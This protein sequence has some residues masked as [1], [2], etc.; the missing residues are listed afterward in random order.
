LNEIRRKGI[1]GPPLGKNF[2]FFIDDLNMPAL[3]VYGAQPPIEL[4]RQW[5][6]FKG[7]YDRKAIGEFRN[8]VDISFC[9]AMGP[10]GGGRN[11]ISMRLTRHFNHLSFVEME[12]DVM[13]T[14]FSTISK[15]WSKNGSEQITELIPKLVSSCLTVYKTIS[16]QLLPT[17]AKSHYTFNLRDLSK[18]FQ[19]ILMVDIKSVENGEDLA[20]LWFHES[21]RVF[22]D[23]LI[24][25]EDRKWFSD[26]LKERMKADFNLN[27]DSVITKE[28]I[29]YGDFMVANTDNKPYIEINDFTQMKKTIEDYLEDYNQI[30]TPKMKLVLFLDAMRHIARIS[31]IIRQPFGNALLLG[32]GG[33]GRQS[34]TRLAAHM[35]DY[36]CFQIELSKNYGISEWKE[37]LKKVM[38]DA[39]LNNAQTVFL[40]N[41][42]QIKSES[43][44]EDLNNILNSGDVPNIYTIDELDNIY[45]TMKPVAQEAGLPPTKTNLFT[46]YTKRVRNNLHSVVCM[47]PI[48]EIFRARLRQFPALVNCCTIDWFSEWPRD[49]LESVAMTFLQEMPDLEASDEIVNGLMNICQEMHQT[50]VVESKRFREEQG[51]INYVT[52]TSYL[53]LLSIFSK[54][55]GQKKNDLIQSKKRT[56]TG[57]DKLLLTEK[58]VTKLRSELE[59][60]QPLL[61]EAVAETISTMATIAVDSKIAAETRAI[62]QKEENEA[63]A[64][65]KEAKA[66]ADDAQKELDESLP[67]LDAALSSLKSLNRGDVTEVKAMGRPPEGVKMVLEAVCIMKKVPPKKVAGEKPGTKVDDYTEGAR[68]LLSDPGKFLD[69]LFSYDRDN[70]ADSVIQKIEPYI[71]SELFQPAKIAT[72]SKA[73]MSICLWVRAMY[74]YHFVNKSVEPKRETMRIANEELAETQRNLA[75]AKS[76]LKEVEESLAT[77]QAKYEDSVKKKAD[78]EFKVKECEEKVVR[79]GK[80]VSGLGDEKIRWA[81]NVKYLE[82]LIAN[83]IGDVLVS[84]GFIAYLGPFTSQYREL[85]TSKWIAHLTNFKVPHTESPEVI[86]T[87][88]DPVKIRNWQ[89]AGLPKDTLS[90]QNGIIVQYTQR[91]PL[92]IDPQGQANKWV[93]NFEK[94]NGIDIIKLSD[95]DFL[96]SLENAIRFGKP[97]LLENVAT[98]LDPALEPV[99]LRQVT[100]H[101]FIFII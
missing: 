101:P 17:P 25:D 24:N 67:A 22:Q 4:I 21:C 16:N 33:S 6:D 100:H 96:R 50:V 63:I 31:R 62:V 37:D 7:W 84:S 54:I 53:E 32:V 36:S 71:N 86:K 79:A 41:D 30:N 74:S 60:M 57:L 73:C 83:V 48:G 82:G 52:P 65:A 2:I 61:E 90:V 91:W 11:Q 85:M 59:S 55:F 95:R 19:G 97:C 29:I 51:R 94:E 89:L 56:K 49:A 88:G 99:L 13:M 12:D 80:L 43:F 76:K 47:S 9:C 14:I 34:L 18:V 58:E 70:I 5:M 40:F 93:K 3:E 38:L 8:L 64:K 28:P 46:S 20:K 75:A 92:F 45:T 35:S 78:L 1:Y 23:R 69:G 98:E 68:N 27:Y 39:G 77:L 10:P 42:T 81:E 72:V 26:L 44:L 87:L 15:W 66:L